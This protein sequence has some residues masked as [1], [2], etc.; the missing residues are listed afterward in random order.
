MATYYVDPENGLD[1]NDGLTTSTPWKLIPGQTG[2]NTVVSTDVINVKNGTVS[3]GGRIQPPANNLTYRGYG[4]ATNVLYLNLP[5][6][7]IRMNKVVK[8]VRESGVHEG[9]WT[10]NAVGTGVSGIEIQNARTNISMSDFRILGETSGTVNA[11]AVGTSAATTS[12]G[13]T[14]S[15]FEIVGASNNGMVVYKP[16]ISAS[17]FKISNV[18]GDG[19]NISAT[20]ANSYRS[21]ITDSFTN[22]EIV[23]PNQ[24]SSGD[25]L[26]DSGDAWQ[27]FHDAGRY[28]G[29]LTVSNWT[30][31]KTNAIKQAFL[32]CDG[33][34]GITID[35]FRILGT[36]T[37]CNTALV[38]CTRGNVRITN[39]YW[40]EGIYLNGVVR[41]RAAE[42]ALAQLLYTGA[43]LTISKNIVN[44]VN[45]DNF[46]DAAE[47]GSTLEMDGT[48]NITHNT[49]VGNIN[50]G[51]V[52]SGFVSLVGGNTTYGANFVLNCIN[53]VFQ[54]TG[55]GVRLP[56][57]TA[58]VARYNVDNN[59][60]G[61]AQTFSIGATVYASLTEFAAAHNAAVSNLTAATL[62]K[63]TLYP[64][65]A[66]IELGQVTT[67]K[68]DASGRAFYTTPSIGALER[69]VVRGTRESLYAGV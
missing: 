38:T 46:F 18:L 11:L 28:E 45:V 56:T 42:T 9:M 69:E 53:N 19:W 22:F 35:R 32:V 44:A 41:M 49:V 6:R 61:T 57:G 29:K 7:D 48:L 63:P 25:V 36:P 17:Y 3:T 1:S 60:F 55:Y 33:L 14:L 12:G 37:S 34:N 39:G 2:A 15:R 8:V 23:N 67:E 68:T 27:T 20:A 64:T 21:G 43:S 59:G 50:G 26:G 4:V 52:Y 54:G 30:A 40:Q 66:V 10:L 62:V 13:V 24:N 16:T 47:T 58:G 65:T 51:T 31:R 5:G